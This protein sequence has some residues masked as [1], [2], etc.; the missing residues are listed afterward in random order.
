MRLGQLLQERELTDVRTIRPNQSLCEA[1]QEMLTHKAAILAVTDDEN[2]LVGTIS[3]HDLTAAINAFVGDLR[4]KAVNQSMTRCSVS[5]DVNDD[6]DEVFTF[7][8]LNNIYC[9]PVFEDEQ[10]SGIISLDELALAYEVFG[11]KSDT[12]SLSALPSRRTFIQILIKE[13]SRSK[14]YGRV[15]SLAIMAIDHFK[16]I[17]EEYGPE[18]GE[19]VSEDIEKI[20]LWQ[21]RN[22]DWVARLGEGEFVAIFPETD[23]IGAEIACERLL[24]KIKFSKM[25]FEPEHLNTSISIGLTQLDEQRSTAS[26]LLKRADELLYEAKAG[27]GDRIEMENAAADSLDRSLTATAT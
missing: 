15:M 1:A 4:E 14:R 21:F 3:Q 9:I 17:N 24:A 10:L 23:Q 12:D 19:K 6:V 26:E 2:H 11:V 7:L 18:I 20:I 16:Q 13:I 25:Q 8:K 5:C 22:V 27:G